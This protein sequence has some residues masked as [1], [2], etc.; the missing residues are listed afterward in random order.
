MI[1][2]KKIQQS[3]ISKIYKSLHD[4][5]ISYHIEHL[6]LVFCYYKTLNVISKSF[7]CLKLFASRLK[8]FLKN[9][10]VCFVWRSDYEIV[11]CCAQCQNTV[12]GHEKYTISE[13]FNLFY[14]DW[15]RDLQNVS[16]NCYLLTALART[17]ND[18]E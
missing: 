2:R 4:K 10:R 18:A 3:A 1:K 7:I 11:K 13:G 16:Q 15:S 12:V 8:M 17:K 14:S 9:I 6:N 5:N